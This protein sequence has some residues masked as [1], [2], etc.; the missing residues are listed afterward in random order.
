MAGDFYEH[1]QDIKRRSTDRDARMYKVQQIRKGNIDLIAPGLLPDSWPK[2]VIANLFRVSA[3]ESAEMLA[4][5]PSITCTPLDAA[6]DT[7]RRKAD[8][9]TEIANFYVDASRWASNMLTAADQYLTYGFLPYRVEANMDEQRPHIHLD[10]PIGAYYDRDRWGRVVAYAQKWK[11]PSAKLARMFPEHANRIWQASYNS[12]V[13]EIVKW[14]DDDNCVLFLENNAAIPLAEYRN[15]ISRC[16][17]AVAELPDLDADRHGEFDDVVWTYLAR[18]YMEMLKL[19]AADQAVNAPIALPEDVQDL[20]IGPDAIIR[21]NTPE[22]IR[23]IGLDMPNS[24]LVESQQLDR[25]AQIGARHP[26][27]RTG[28][29]NASIITGKGVEALMGGFDS[30]IKAG[31]TMNAEAMREAISMAFE[32]DEK[33]WPDAK[34]EVRAM[35]AGRPY[36]LKYT[37]ARDIKGDHTV[38]VNYGL[39]AGMDPNHALVFALQARG[40][41]LLSRDLVRRNLPFNADIAEEERKI[42]IEKMRDALMQGALGYAQAIPLMAQQ[43]MDPL[44]PVRSLATAIQSRR[45]GDSVEDAILAAFQPPEPESGVEQATDGRESTEP[46][47]SGAPPGSGAPNSQT[48]I[49]PGMNPATGQ[50]RSTAPGQAGMPPGGM[51]DVAMA[52]AGLSPSGNA[53]LQYNVSRRRALG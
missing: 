2:P 14:Y 7:A 25:E 13:V 53:N 3:R 22:K 42:D 28:N 45:S 31:Q 18:A 24:A 44:G 40:D 26:S 6:D 17:V 41:D 39:M 37:P 27:A 21:S 1:W 46:G 33:V 49:P 8:R 15:P 35:A 52:L 38:E 5:L 43:G 4:P 9:R 47:E 50:L 48:S 32:M 51:P 36:A 20:A 12:D 34:K 10:D 29:I 30:K 19:K 23:R 11:E 16:P